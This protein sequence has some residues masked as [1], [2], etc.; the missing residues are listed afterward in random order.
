MPTA[1]NAL[2]IDVT[3]GFELLKTKASSLKDTDPTKSLLLRHEEL[4]NQPRDPA[5][6]ERMEAALRQGIQDSLT[7]HG[8]DTQRVELPVV[9]CRTT[10]CEIQAIGFREDNAKKGV[11]I[12]MIVP[13]LLMGPLHSE[14]DNP[15]GRMSSLPDGRLSY[16]MLL[17]RRGS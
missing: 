4:R 9:E 2:P 5:W 8:V 12:Q 10:G 16:I 14:L 3:P 13:A 7:A 6:S 17:G 11:G 15:L 1:D